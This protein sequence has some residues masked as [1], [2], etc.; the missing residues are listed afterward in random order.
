MF[1]KS[2]RSIPLTRDTFEKMLTFPE[3]IVLNHLK[4]PYA[5]KMIPSM[6]VRKHHTKSLEKWYK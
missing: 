2:A 6:F 4:E 1:G 5:M 3:R